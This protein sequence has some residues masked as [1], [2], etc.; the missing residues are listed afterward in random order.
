M[1]SKKTKKELVGF[2]HGGVMCQGTV[3]AVWAD[4]DD[5]EELW[6]HNAK[7]YGASGG[8][9]CTLRYV[10]V[11]DAEKEFKKFTKKLGKDSC[12]CEENSLYGGTSVNNA[13]D[14]LKKVTDV[15][16]CNMY[17]GSDDSD[18]KETKNSKSKAKNKKT[19]KGKKA[20]SDDESDAEESDAEESDA[21]E[22][23][24]EESDAEES[25]SDADNSD[26]SESESEPEVQTKS[27]SKK[28]VK[29]KPKAKTKGKGKGK[30]K[31]K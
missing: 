17:K 12:V 13:R 11:E 26:N 28:K 3:K 22:S 9:R 18:E 30:G 15:A 29:A 24:A 23:D 19:K 25:E 27:K 16:K 10:P 21:E 6:A 4:N 5:R 14:V 20:E 8:K 1:P 7:Y 2:M 31:G